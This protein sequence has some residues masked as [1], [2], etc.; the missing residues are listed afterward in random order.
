MQMYYGYPEIFVDL[1]IDVNNAY[2][3]GCAN[4]PIHHS[5]DE[6]KEPY[7]VGLRNLHPAV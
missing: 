7:R 1:S 5:A 3:A 6:Y 4:L 2:Y